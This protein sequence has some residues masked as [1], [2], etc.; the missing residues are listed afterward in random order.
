VRRTKRSWGRAVS[1]FLDLL[2]KGRTADKED[3]IGRGKDIYEE[4]DQNRTGGEIQKNLNVCQ[5]KTHMKILGRR[6]KKSLVPHRPYSKKKEVV[7]S[8]EP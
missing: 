1:I 6:G 2:R 7:S 3:T 8:G 5:L 4:K